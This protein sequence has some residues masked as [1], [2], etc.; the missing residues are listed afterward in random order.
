MEKCKYTLNNNYGKEIDK[1]IKCKNAFTK[2]L[3]GFDYF[4]FF[5]VLEW[6]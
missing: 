6:I 4:S 3:T 2:I 1:H 5:C